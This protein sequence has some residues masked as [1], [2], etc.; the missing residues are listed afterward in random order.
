MKDGDFKAEEGFVLFVRR[1]HQAWGLHEYF[2]TFEA[3]SQEMDR[4]SRTSDA[5]VKLCRSDEI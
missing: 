3:A 4:L 2:V 5:P 1:N